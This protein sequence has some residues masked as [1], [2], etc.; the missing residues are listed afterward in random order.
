MAATITST[1]AELTL[2]ALAK[3]DIVSRVAAAV[4]AA[5]ARAKARQDYRRLLDNDELMRD[6]GI[7]REDV[8]RALAELGG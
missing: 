1:P 2:S 8:R 7:R 3:Q 6:A 4:A 5:M